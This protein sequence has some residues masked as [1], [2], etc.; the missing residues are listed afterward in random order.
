MLTEQ[1]CVKR[2]KLH[3][4]HQLLESIERTSTPSYGFL[5]FSLAG[6]VHEMPDCAHVLLG[7]GYMHIPI[8]IHLYVN[9][10]GLDHCAK[11]ESEI[12]IVQKDR[13][14]YADILVGR[15]QATSWTLAA[16]SID[17]P[18]TRTSFE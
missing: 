8:F 14:F 3:G 6:S 2:C 18:L 16:L 1:G 7:P 17:N 5:S 4:F 10:Q 11:F 13:K 15:C 12:V 9:S